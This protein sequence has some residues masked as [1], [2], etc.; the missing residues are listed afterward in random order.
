MEHGMLMHT[1]TDER[2]IE[3]RLFIQQDE[4]EVQG[5]APVSGYDRGF[6]GW[7]YE[8]RIGARLERGDIW[9]WAQ[10]SVEASYKGFSGWDH[11]GGCSYENT[12]GF[13]T[14][15]GYW[16]DM[17]DQVRAELLKNVRAAATVVAELAE[18][19]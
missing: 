10:V 17:K 2:G 16:P 7:D 5:N 8:D 19:I 1:E 14:P 18:V 15:A 9:A 6:S 3:Y 4:F 11:L 12:E 13:I